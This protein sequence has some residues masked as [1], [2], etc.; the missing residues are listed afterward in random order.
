MFRKKNSRQSRLAAQKLSS[1]CL[2]SGKV[3]RST[4]ADIE[5]AISDGG[6]RQERKFRSWDKKMTKAWRL[7]FEGNCYPETGETGGKGARD[8]S[9]STR[10]VPQRWL[11]QLLNG[12]SLWL[13]E[14]PWGKFLPASSSSSSATAAGCQVTPVSAIDT[15]PVG[16]FSVPWVIPRGGLRHSVGYS[17]T[18]VTRIKI[19]QSRGA[20]INGSEVRDRP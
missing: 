14:R 1:K 4:A 13:Q 7:I 9:W 20:K 17:E 10:R 8:M 19:Q 3:I 11:R 16:P 15:L 18:L 12:E 5:E 6:N 2:H